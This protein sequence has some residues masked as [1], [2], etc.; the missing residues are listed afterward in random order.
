MLEKDKIL[1]DALDLSSDLFLCY[2]L[3][4]LFVG[5]EKIFLRERKWATLSE[6]NKSFKK[7][8]SV[9]FHLS[10]VVTFEY[11]QIVAIY[12]SAGSY[13]I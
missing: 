13:A 4:A 7:K 1:K 6:E 9:S 2:L 10:F 5:N 8:L 12:W 3:Y 11:D